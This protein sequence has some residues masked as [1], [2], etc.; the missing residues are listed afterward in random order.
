MFIRYKSQQFGSSDN[1]SSYSCKIIQYSNITKELT[2][3]YASFGFY[4]S[5]RQEGCGL[6]KSNRLRRGALGDLGVF[7]AVGNVGA[8]TAVE[9][10]DGSVGKLGDVLVGLGLFFGGHELKG[11]F[12]CDSEWIVRLDG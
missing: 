4:W 2:F 11:A 9:H 1:N 5:V 3:N 6:F 7:L 10:G 8:V 12:Q